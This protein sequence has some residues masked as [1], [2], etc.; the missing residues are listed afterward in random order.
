MPDMRG[1]IQPGL[2]SMFVHRFRSD[3]RAVLHQCPRPAI[4]AP[5]YENFDASANPYDPGIRFCSIY[6]SR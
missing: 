5:L 4:V 2:V 6:L 1:L 3:V